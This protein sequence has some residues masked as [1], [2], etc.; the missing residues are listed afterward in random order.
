MKVFKFSLDPTREADL[1]AFLNGIP[2]KNERGNW[3]RRAVRVYRELEKAFLYS[4]ERQE[5]I[6]E[7]VKRCL[8][9]RSFRN[10]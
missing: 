2:S 5:E 10:R 7:T 9:E 8:E 1:I 4:P 3:I 6:L